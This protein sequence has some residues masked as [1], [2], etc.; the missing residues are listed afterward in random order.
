MESTDPRNGDGADALTE[1]G[2]LLAQPI[3]TLDLAYHPETYPK[4]TAIVDFIW[5]GWRLSPLENRL[6]VVASGYFRDD[7][8]KDL[9]AEVLTSTLAEVEPRTSRILL[10]AELGASEWMD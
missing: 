8:G 9:P 4:L 5:P 2:W 1:A 6:A 7:S 3:G 10:P